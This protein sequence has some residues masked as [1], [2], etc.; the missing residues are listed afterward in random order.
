MN[1]GLKSLSQLHKELIEKKNSIN[2]LFDEF[3]V[4]NISEEVDY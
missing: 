4:P 3:D 2:K 1:S